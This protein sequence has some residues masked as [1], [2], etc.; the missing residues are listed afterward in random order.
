[1]ILTKI[2]IELG[3]KFV[4]LIDQSAQTQGLTGTDDYLAQWSWGDELEA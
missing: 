4:A 3:P 1:M 2:K